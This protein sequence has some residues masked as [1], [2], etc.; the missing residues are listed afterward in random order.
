[1]TVR[2]VRAL[3][4]I[5]FLTPPAARA[6]FCSTV[7]DAAF[8]QHYDALVAATENARRAVGSSVVVDIAVTF[9]VQ[10]RGG[11]PVISD[12]RLGDAVQATNRWYEAAGV[13]FVKCGET[14]LFPETGS[15]KL[16]ARTI[17]VALYRQA[18]GC[19][20]TAGSYVFINVACSRTLENILSHELGHVM[21]LPH[22]HGYTNT[23]TTDELADG[24]NCTTAG[25]RFCDTPADPNLLGLVNGACAYVGT[26]K[27]ARGMPY[28]PLPDNIMSYTNSNCAD[29]LTPM[30]Y[31]RVRAVA[32]ASPYE[33]CLLE[34]PLVSDTAVCTGSSAILHASTPVGTLA[35]FDVPKGGTP[36]GFGPEFTTPPL[37]SARAWYVEAVDSCTSPRALVVV[38]INPPSGVI[39]DGARLVQD[40]DTADSSLPYGLFVLDPLLI[41]RTQS[42]LWATDGSAAGAFPLK[43]ID[44]SQGE[45]GIS[46]VM[47]FGNAVLF[48]M[49]DP[50]NGPSLWRADPGTRMVTELRRFAPRDGFSNFWITD[51]GGWALFMLNDGT[52]RTELWRTDGTDTGTLLFATLPETNAFADFS[53]TAF[54]GTVIFQA[55]DSLHGEELWITDGTAQGTHMLVDIRPGMESSDPTDFTYADGRLYFSATDSAYGRELWVTDGTTALCRRISDIN[56]GEGSSNITEIT[57]LDGLLYFSATAE[58]QN[59]EPF[60]S[61]GTEDGARR[62]A[63]IDFLKGS[64]PSHFT[65]FRDEVYCVAS[66][67]SG[68][69]LWALHPQGAAA[70]RCVRNINPVAS[71]SIGPLLAWNGLLFFAANDGRHG[72]ELWR[73]DGT[74][75]GTYLLA[76][77]DT[78]AGRSGAPMYLT[79][80]RGGLYFTANEKYI[81]R[82]L[83]ALSTGEPTTCNGSPALLTAGNTEGEVRWYDSEDAATPLG[84]GASWLTSPLTR[85]RTY[86]ADLTVGACSSARTAIQV[87]VL[88]PDP[89]LRDTAVTSGADV[90]LRAFAE[91][92]EIE[93]YADSAFGPALHFGMELLLAR[94]MHDTTVYAST[95]EG[96][97]RRR[98]SPLRIRVGTSGIGGPPLASLPSVFPHPVR[99]LLQIRLHGESGIEELIIVDMLG[100]E[101][102]RLSVHDTVDGILRVSLDGHPDGQYLAV[103]RGREGQRILRYLKVR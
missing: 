70:P 19:G 5:I 68:S 80:F 90:L 48:G 26:G 50:V 58:P 59:F 71:S 83:Y 10:L 81:G 17:N 41:F 65:A 77:I 72:S 99:E 11:V 96:G 49:N 43:R 56:P 40:L 91:S 36:V 21:G 61:D 13:R 95:R 35:W 87:R 44:R 12:A 25:D 97:C 39:L 55:N 86:W 63:E 82:E 93:W 6:Q 98:R 7:T 62:L 103:L 102:L 3:L 100:R 28:H 51:A 16:N 29:S 66:D 42:G 46:S 64:F 2:T 92:G 32:L 1:M 47:A 57:A 79:P 78:G 75:A 9:H 31:A 37:T 14:D 76:D 52:D 84:I 60:V 54:R 22:T 74:E 30:Q 69:E 45:A 8:M 15:P 24:S 88:A 38:G 101:L 27:D 53:F 23:G 20:Y 94:V 33:C 73:S 85:S 18:D 89:L 67:G 4:L 34:Q